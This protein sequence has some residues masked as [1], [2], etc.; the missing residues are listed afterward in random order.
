MRGETSHKQDFLTNG[1]ENQL[2][3]IQLLIS[4]IQEDLVSQ[5]N[6]FPDK[7]SSCKVSIQMIC[8]FQLILKKIC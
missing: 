4:T 1:R 5:S 3:L 2:S 8:K 7:S 6:S